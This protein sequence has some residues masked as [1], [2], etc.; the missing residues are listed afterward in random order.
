MNFLNVTKKPMDQVIETVKNFCS[1]P[2]NEVCHFFKQKDHDLDSY[3]KWPPISA[4]C[5]R[6]SQL[7]NQSRGREIPKVHLPYKDRVLMACE[8]V[9]H[10]KTHK[11]I[12]IAPRINIYVEDRVLSL[13]KRGRKSKK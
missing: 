1:K 8:K 5:V 6:L 4:N 13:Y 2:W 7:K 12:V 9:V 10:L 3:S 11:W